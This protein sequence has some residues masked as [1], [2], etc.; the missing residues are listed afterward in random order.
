MKKNLE[1]RICV[2]LTGLEDKDW[3]SKLDEINS[4][5]LDTVALILE[6]FSKKQRQLIYEALEDSSVKHVPLIHLKND[7]SREELEFLC[8]RFKSKYLTIHEDSFKIIEKW[9]GHYQNLF[10]E[11]NFDDY[12]AQNVK[13]EKIGGFCVDLAHFKAAEEKWSKEFEYTIQR[14]NNKDIFACN[15]LSGYSAARNADEHD[16][17][18]I[19][20][21]E[22]LKTLPDFVFGKVIAL[23]VYNSI[24]EQL[25]FKK[26]II[27]LLSSD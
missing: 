7:M 17:K 10:L 13:V 5:G 20:D 3:Q 21:F 14:R 8:D 19:K 25:E 23:E 18:S 1:Q 22:Y 16:P 24:K 4:L 26:Q 2:S 27:K 11:F 15:H 6:S 9:H 12:V